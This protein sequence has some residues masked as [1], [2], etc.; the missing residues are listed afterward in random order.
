M[1]RNFDGGVDKR[2]SSLRIRFE[3]NGGL[4][5]ETLK[6]H[7]APLPPTPANVKYALRVAAEVRKRIGAGTF[8]YGEFFPDSKFAERPKPA[9]VSSFGELAGQW[10]DSKGQLQAA[11]QDQYKTA[12]RFWKKLLGEHTP[13]PELTDKVLKAKI[14]KH[15][16][17][18]PK[19][20]NNYLIALRG[21]LDFE[22]SGRRAIEN[23]MTG[24]KNLPVVKKLPDPLTVAERDQILADMRTRCDPRVYAYFV[25][26]FF[27][28]MRPEET[29][30][31]RWSD[32]DFN[33]SVCRVQ[34]VRTFRGAER[35]GSKT[36]AERDVDLVDSALQALETMRRYTF[37]KRNED[38][39]E[40]CVFENPITAR[41]WHDERSQRDHYWRPSL[42][43]LGVRWRRP[44]NTRHT[45]C[46]VA[47]MGSVN[48]AYIAA[49]AGHSVKMLLEKYARWIPA[50]DGG[51]ERKRLAAAQG[52]T[53]R[54]A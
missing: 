19:A 31:L 51:S 4:R 16:W 21:V 44:Y 39:S 36:N 23:P 13:V 49:Q 27:T 54:A 3:W 40:V 34:R 47:L 42:K 17:P 1:G 8:E 22:Y 26:Q 24:I 38:G 48:P 35:D 12:V 9:A 52:A 45:Y 25:W 5:R 41:P 43:R 2:P 53:L 10:L 32:I 11:T 7:G 18:S 29:I 33:T 20:H 15:P 6:L 50:N 37:G 28:G 30:A 14:G 46:T